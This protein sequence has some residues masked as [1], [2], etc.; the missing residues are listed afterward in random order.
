[1]FDSRSLAALIALLALCGAAA[2]RTQRKASP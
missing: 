2:L 1:M